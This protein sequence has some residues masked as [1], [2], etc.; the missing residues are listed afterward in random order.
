MKIKN[1]CLLGATFII[2]L[3]SVAGA[4]PSDVSPE[5]RE[6]IEWCDVWISHA[7]ETNL[8]RVLLIGD[9]ITRAY[10]PE[11]EKHLAGKAYVARLATSR[12]ASDPVLIQEIALVLD[13][14]KFDV[15]HFNNGMHGWQHAETE[16]RNAFPQFL[17]AIKSH[18]PGAK[19]IWAT[20]TSLK[21]SKPLPP[22]DRT[23]ASDERIAARNAI[24][25]EYLGPQ[26][27]PMDDLNALVRGHPEYHSDNV[28]FNGQGIALEAAQVASQIEK[29]LQQ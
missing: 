1:Q 4:A 14:A 23:H 24:A 21:E 16:Y 5:S 19:L 12:F 3:L 26:R 13:N 15:I 29:L 18:A 22:D 7:N 28:H 2:C 6:S 11:V 10:Y 17:A 25:L 8:P 27:I 20:T 9:S